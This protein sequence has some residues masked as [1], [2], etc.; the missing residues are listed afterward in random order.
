MKHKLLSGY[1]G[2]FGKNFMYSI[3]SGWKSHYFLVR[4][5]CNE[6][7][8]RNGQYF[9][10]RSSC[11]PY[12]DDQIIFVTYQTIFS[13]KTFSS[14]SRISPSTSY[15]T[16]YHWWWFSLESKCFLMA[17]IHPKASCIPYIVAELVIIFGKDFM[18]SIN[19]GWNGHYLW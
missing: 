16:W 6:Y 18:Y 12:I 2:K 1:Y 15:L 5:A 14:K 9:L 3:N 17:S 13:S 19:S 10:V 11:I 8:G 7:S 4:A